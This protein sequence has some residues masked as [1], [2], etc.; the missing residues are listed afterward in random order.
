MYNVLAWKDIHIQN[1]KD[2]ISSRRAQMIH[3]PS[4]PSQLDQSSLQ[5]TKIV[6]G[7]CETLSVVEI[8]EREMLVFPGQMPSPE[9]KEINLSHLKFFAWNT[10]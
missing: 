6:Q 5:P 9:H 3:T 1:L 4:R 7:L 8:R 10:I 2:H